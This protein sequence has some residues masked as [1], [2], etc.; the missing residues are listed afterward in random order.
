[1]SVLPRGAA[2]R[3]RWSFLKQPD[4][5]VLREGDMCDVEVVYRLNRHC[6]DSCWSVDA[7]YSA[8]ESGCDLLLCEHD[9]ELAGYLLTMS[10]LDEV[11]VLQIAVDERFRRQGLAEAMTQELIE[12][13]SGI[14]KIILEVR[15][16]NRAA[17]MLYGKLGFIESGCRKNYYGPDVHGLY[18]DAIL[19]DL[20]VA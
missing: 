8:L 20:K 12:R 4:G 2:G 17:R 14:S 1:M 3:N 19:M 9:N 18:E 11:Q 5:Y 16:S 15:A 7:I 13:R 10:I 6:F